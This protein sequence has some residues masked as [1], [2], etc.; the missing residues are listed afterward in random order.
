VVH[1]KALRGGVVLTPAIPRSA[2]GK[3][4]RRDLRALVDMSVKAML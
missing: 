2:A 3:I 1:Y 4:L